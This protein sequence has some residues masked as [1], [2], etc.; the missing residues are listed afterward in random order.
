M[1]ETNKILVLVASIWLIV[2]CEEQG[3][4]EQLGEEIDEAV[5][6]AR[7]GEEK[8]ENQ[9]DDVADEVREGIDEVAGEIDDAVE[10]TQP[11]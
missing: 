8:L 6:D 2:A 10:E 3:P 1:K 9:M 5:E 7:A 11:E 4:A